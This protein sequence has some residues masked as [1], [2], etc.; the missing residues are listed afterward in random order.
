[1]SIFGFAFLFA[2]AVRVCCACLD[3]GLKK[4]SCS[5]RCTY[6]YSRFVFALILF[7]LLI[8]IERL[9]F[10]PRVRIVRCWFGRGCRVVVAAM[11][12][13]LRFCVSQLNM[14]D[15]F[16]HI[17]FS[18]SSMHRQVRKYYHWQPNTS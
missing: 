11:F 6:A 3:A 4:I 18:S 12:A 5:S 14:C 9:R 1:M 10:A 13:S 16:M 15:A 7:M 17:E 8:I 2:L